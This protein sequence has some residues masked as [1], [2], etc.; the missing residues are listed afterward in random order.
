MYDKPD[1]AKG[2]RTIHNLSF[3]AHTLCL[4]YHVQV[5]NCCVS[6]SDKAKNLN[7]LNTVENF[8]SD[9]TTIPLF[10]L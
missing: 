4:N 6:R 8:L 7:K 9:F 1:F 10:R 5:N 3:F 2:S